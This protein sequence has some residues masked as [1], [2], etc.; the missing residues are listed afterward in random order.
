MNDRSARQPRDL[1]IVRKYAVQLQVAACFLFRWHINTSI[2]AHFTWWY[3]NRIE[4]LTIKRVTALIKVKFYVILILNR[5]LWIPDI[6]ILV[7][8]PRALMIRRI[9]EIFLFP[10]TVYAVVMTLISY[11]FVYMHTDYIVLCNL[12]HWRNISTYVHENF[13]IEN[14]NWFLCL[15]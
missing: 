9:L 13:W 4:V 6:S 15:L 1:H 5:Q 11:N 7:C 8:A 3:L 10:F 14:R 2:I 12:K